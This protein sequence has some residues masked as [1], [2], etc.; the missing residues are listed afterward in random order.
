MASGQLAG[1]QARCGSYEHDGPTSLM[2]KNP[3]LQRN[4][5]SL[6]PTESD[7]RGHPGASVRS[8]GPALCCIG[9]WTSPACY[10]A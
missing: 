10:R 8:S 3:D 1:N 7:A 6:G 9:S 4:N 2:Q 5:T